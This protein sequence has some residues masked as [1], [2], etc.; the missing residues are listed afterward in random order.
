MAEM[1]CALWDLYP[2]ELAKVDLTSAIEAMANDLVAANGLDVRCSFDGIVRRLP[3]EAE[4]GLLRISQEALSNV[5]KHARASEV[6]IDL[7]F[8]AHQARLSV[9]DDGRGFQVDRHPAGLGLT[10]MQNRTSA[11]GGEW[12][13]SSGAGRGTEVRVSIPIPPAMT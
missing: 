5:L 3:P 8:D 7:S 10:S 13:I 4:R 2:E 12:A 1:R 11:L 6:R 9:R